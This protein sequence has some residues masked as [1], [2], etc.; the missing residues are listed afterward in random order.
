[1]RRPEQARI[2]FQPEKK[3][4]KK[5]LARDEKAK[6]GRSTA[7]PLAKQDT[8]TSV[9]E[10]QGGFMLEAS[11]M[12]SPRS[13]GSLQSGGAGGNL[14]PEMPNVSDSSE[15]MRSA[16]KDDIGETRLATWQMLYCGGSQPVV[17]ALEKIKK[18][19]EISLK[20]EKFDW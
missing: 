20:V 9:V 4:S 8:R 12:G 2:A 13:N 6:E 1:M 14:S 3:K 5:N 16:L 19:F 7:P 18:K 17:D 10:C 15:N 11:K